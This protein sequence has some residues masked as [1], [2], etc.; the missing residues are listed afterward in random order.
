MTVCPPGLGKRRRRYDVLI[1]RQVV[2]LEELILRRG[3]SGL[4]E[5]DLEKWR[6]NF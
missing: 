4:G 1:R 5:G 2:Q 6:G 3:K